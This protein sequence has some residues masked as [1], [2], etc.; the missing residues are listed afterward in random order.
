MVGKPTMAQR[1]NNTINILAGDLNPEMS[2]YGGYGTTESK[3]NTYNMYTKGQTVADFAYFQNLNFYVP[4]GTTAGE[5]MLTVT[6]NRR[7][8]QIQPWRLYKTARRPTVRWMS[9]APRSL[10][11]S[12]EIRS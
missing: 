2:L 5:T 3:N 4:E 7:L 1:D 8:T 10:A 11:V 12:R 9:P 6:G